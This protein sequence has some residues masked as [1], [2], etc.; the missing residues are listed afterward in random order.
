MDPVTFRVSGRKTLH[1]ESKLYVLD[2]FRDVTYQYPFIYRR[3]CCPLAIIFN[4]PVLF[5]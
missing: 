4:I 3:T 5:L 1:F 2:R